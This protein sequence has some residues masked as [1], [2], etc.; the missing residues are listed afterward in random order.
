MPLYFSAVKLT[1]SKVA[2]SHL[3]P[4]S[5]SVCNCASAIAHSDR[6]ILLQVA[7]AFGSLTAG[8]YMRRT[9]KFYWMA[10]F[11]CCM[12]LAAT[13]HLATWGPDTPSWSLW[14]SLAPFG[15]GVSGILTSTLVTLI[16]SVDKADIACSTGSK[17]RCESGYLDALN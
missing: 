5:V 10:A 2:G 6:R 8:W 12:S 7:L 14:V 9:G 4:N 11:M 17:C 1:T 16:G 15:F 3:V 13:I